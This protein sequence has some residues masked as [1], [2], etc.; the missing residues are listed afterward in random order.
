MNKSL[1]GGAICQRKIIYYCD[2]DKRI[3]CKKTNCKYLNEG[4]CNGTSDESL[5]LRSAD[6]RPLV[7]YVLDLDKP[8][9]ASRKE[10]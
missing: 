2:P 3:D 7:L 8:I 4:E 10:E 1:S 9:S 6:G 5:A